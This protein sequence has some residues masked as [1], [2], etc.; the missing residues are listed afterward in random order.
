MNTFSDNLQFT[1]YVSIVSSLLIKLILLWRQQELIILIDSKGCCHHHYTNYHRA[2][3]S[4]LGSTTKNFLTAYKSSLPQTP[5]TTQDLLN[6]NHTYKQKL[7]LTVP[8]TIKLKV[9][10]AWIWLMTSCSCLLRTINTKQ[11]PEWNLSVSD[12]F[13]CR[14]VISVCPLATWL[15]QKICKTS[16]CWHTLTLSLPACPWAGWVGGGGGY[17]VVLSAG[18]SDRGSPS[19]NMR[20]VN[21]YLSFSS[22]LNNWK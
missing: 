13:P 9:V 14:L 4:S 21:S 20:Q 2:N 3:W 7:Q 15:W 10:E 5:P 16:H 19:N 18:Q 17:W 11:N 12:S 8:V 1:I 6:I 22:H